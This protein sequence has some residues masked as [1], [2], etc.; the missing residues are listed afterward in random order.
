MRPGNILKVALQCLIQQMLNLRVSCPEGSE[1]E[2]RLLEGPR[3][4]HRA[5][6]PRGLPRVRA[7]QDSCAQGAA[8]NRCAQGEPHSCHP[9]G[10]WHAG[11]PSPARAASSG[12]RPQADTCGPELS[13]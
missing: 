6:V 9:A 13:M 11:V 3:G 1:P 7:A 4:L 2:A 12:G 8:Q 10:I 5:G